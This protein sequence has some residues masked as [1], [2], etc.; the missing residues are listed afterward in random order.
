MSR[1]PRWPVDHY[2]L[3]AN[4]NTRNRQRYFIRQRQIFSEISTWQQ[5]AK[6][7]SPPLVFDDFPTY[8]AKRSLSRKVL[9]LFYLFIFIEVYSLETWAH[10]DSPGALNGLHAYNFAAPSA[11][12]C[13]FVVTAAL[14]VCP[15]F[16]LLRAPHWSIIRE[17]K[18][19]E[20]EGE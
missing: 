20:K 11:R 12:R 14:V 6:Q 8:V 3:F 9:I 16:A 10:C 1:F 19:K 4:E 18:T 5:H 17:K 2:T 15:F 7:Q 13:R